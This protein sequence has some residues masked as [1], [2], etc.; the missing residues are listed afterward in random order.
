VSG[1]NEERELKL[2]PDDPAL[3]ERLA[4][5]E[6]VGELVAKSRHRELQHNSFFDTPERALTRAR[7]GF[8]RRTIDGHKM[9]T[10]AL[11]AD[12]SHVAGVATRTEI[13]LQLDPDMAPALALSALG[14]A[15]RQRGA[16]VVAQELADALAN[17][18]LPLAAPFLETATERTIVD[19]ESA[20]RGWAIELALDRVRLLGH[21]FQELE[22]EAE[23]KSGDEA[24]FES[25]RHAIEALGKVRDSDG[26]KLS[27]AL[28]HLAG[29]TCASQPN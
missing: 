3:L 16:T 18:G 13:E 1:Q 28:A 20:R 21:D 22:I 24:V 10:W 14:Q 17:G 6:R 27:R 23:L 12:G 2:T 7:M 5:A 9:A 15:A 11:K 26:S 25:V 8:R 4:A 29:C 19:L